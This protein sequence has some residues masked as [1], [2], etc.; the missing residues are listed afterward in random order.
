MEKLL[1]KAAE[2]VQPKRRDWRIG[3][4]G[5]GFI[6]DD[7][8]LVA[9]RN[10]GLNP[11]AIA[12]RTKDHAK[13][14]ADNHGIKKVYESWQQLLENTS[15]EIIDIAFPPDKQLEI[16][17]EACKRPNIKGILC[18]KPLAMSLEDARE[19]V[20]Y[21]KKY[22]KKIAVNSNMRFDPSMRALK[23]LLDTEELGEP[24][25]ATIE[26]RATP[27]WQGFLEEYDKL[28]LYSMGIHHLDIL[29]Y[30]FGNPEEVTCVCRTDPGTPFEHKD[31]ITQYTYHYKR[32]L[33]ATCLDDVWAGPK[34]GCQSNFYI[35]WRVEGTEGLAEGSIGWHKFPE[36]IPSKI[37][38]TSLRHPEWVEPNW[39][40]V[41]FPDAFEGTISELLLAIEND[42]EPSISALDNINTIA[43]VE[44]C[45]KSIDD[46]RTVALSE[47]L[48][49]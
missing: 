4:I 23:Y 11:V 31:G 36:R 48:K 26:M 33:M 37:R 13:K 30:L 41:W 24:V 40:K 49:E 42:S 5:A 22:G 3:C 25:L 47:L 17:K 32:G 10:L 20:R 6:M 16:V 2:P 14:V 43:C 44:A 46:K 39:N 18:Q 27:H 38:F 12:S 34:E 7:C 28:E 21:G 19:I 9:Y 15:L 29:R 45:Y 1:N 8:H 35:K